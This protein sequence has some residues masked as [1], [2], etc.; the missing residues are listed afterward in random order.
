MPAISTDR[1]CVSYSITISGSDNE[2]LINDQLFVPSSSNEVCHDTPPLMVILPVVLLIG[3]IIFIIGCCC[4]CCRRQT[5][6]TKM[7]MYN[8]QQ[9]NEKANN[10][11]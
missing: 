5:N 9:L 7:I 11:V 8:E 4:Y 6:R 3:I 10:Y 2:V 1:R